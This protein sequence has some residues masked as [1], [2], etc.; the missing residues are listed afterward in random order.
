MRYFVGRWRKRKAVQRADR[1]DDRYNESIGRYN[2]YSPTVTQGVVAGLSLVDPVTR[3]AVTG[4]PEPEP[5]QQQQ[6][7]ASRRHGTALQRL[8]RS[9]LH[10]HVCLYDMLMDGI[11]R[12][13]E[14]PLVGARR[15]RDG[16]CIAYQWM[17]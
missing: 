15:F 13:T 12:R 8:G 9:I 2:R 4:L 16:V 1:C 11:L 3:D 14:D 5:E 17:A 10:E 6:R 7:Q